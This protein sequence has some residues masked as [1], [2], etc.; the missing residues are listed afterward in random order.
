MNQMF[1]V[2]LVKP[3]VALAL[4]ALAFVIA[5]AVLKYIP[6]GRFR[7][8]LTYRLPGGDPEHRRGRPLQ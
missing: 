3:F 1:W 7:R 8:L 2:M 4:F 5:H 6:P